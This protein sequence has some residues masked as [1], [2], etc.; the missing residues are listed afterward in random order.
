MPKFSV[1]RGEDAINALHNYIRVIEKK[2][3]RE[4]TRK[5]KRA[6]IKLAEGLISAIKKES[7]EPSTQQEAA[8]LSLASRLKKIMLTRKILPD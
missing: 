1:L 3:S 6:L 4:L 5:Q 2:K 7:T 8:S